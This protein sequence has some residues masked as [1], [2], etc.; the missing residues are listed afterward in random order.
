MKEQE[1]FSAIRCDFGD[2]FEWLLR[3]YNHDMCGMGRVDGECRGY[4]ASVM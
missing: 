1:L 3:D 4:C 2:E